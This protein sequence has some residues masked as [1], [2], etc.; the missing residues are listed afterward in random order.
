MCLPTR[1][2][3]LVA[4]SAPPIALSKFSTR[5]PPLWLSRRGGR[6]SAA[7]TARQEAHRS[8]H[9]LLA[10]LEW[11]SY[12]SAPCPCSRCRQGA[13]MR[14]A[15]R[16]WPLASASLAGGRPAPAAPLALQQPRWQPRR[17]PDSV[18]GS[19]SSSTRQQQQHRRLS[20]ACSASPLQQQT[21]AA[22][23]ASAAPAP[24][25]AAAPSTSG[26]PAEADVLIEFKNVWKSFGRCAEGDE[27][28]KDTSCAVAPRASVRRCRPRPAAPPGPP[29]G[30]PHLP[31]PSPCLQ[32]GHTARGH[33]QDPSG[34][35]GG[36]HR[37]VRHRQVDHAAPGGGPAAAGQGGWA[38]PR[39]VGA[40]GRSGCAAGTARRVR[41]LHNV[42]LSSH[43]VPSWCCSAPVPSRSG[44]GADQGGAAA[45]ADQRRRHVGQAESGAGVPGALPSG[46]PAVRAVLQRWR[47][48]S[49]TCMLAGGGSTGKLDVAGSGLEAFLSHLPHRPPATER[50]AVRLADRGGERGLPAARAHAAATPE[51]P[52]AGLAG[53][54]SAQARHVLSL[55]WLQEVVAGSLGY[56][57]IP[58]QLR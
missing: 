33:L 40:F 27:L 16:P 2:H 19:S 25:P 17:Q 54:S 5:S 8:R 48:G 31:S 46:P 37:V 12:A 49:C 35:G 21:T 56:G 44:R 9:P 43:A 42:P 52:G 1:V 50:R 53:G 15:A 23:D 22:A 7:R 3:A 47:A 41:S 6:P 29:S 30:T 58:A 18:H 20:V 24:A 38:V 11:L 14:L 10:L 28:A 57:K 36:H 45:W 34:R 13:S 4:S 26:R 55:R 32:Q 39:L 51:N